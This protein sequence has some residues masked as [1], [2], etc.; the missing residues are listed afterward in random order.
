M[1]LRGLAISTLALA[2]L[3]ARPSCR[4]SEAQAPAA[5]ADPR[6]RI[7]Q[8]SRDYLEGW[9]AADPDRLGRALHP[10]MVKRHVGGP[11]AGRQLVMSLTRDQMVEM[12]RLGGGSK[13]PDEGRK[14]TV[15]V[16]D[17]SGDIAVAQ[18]SSSEFVEYLSLARCNGDWTIVNILWRFTNPP[19]AR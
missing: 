12:T 19:P 8:V 9:Y 5:P 18:A 17:V 3:L 14:V 2:P 13:V 10:D 11:P 7:E 6:A 15:Q 1:R 16:L 4:A